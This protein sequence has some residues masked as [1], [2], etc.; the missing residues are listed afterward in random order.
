[1]KTMHNP[2]GP[3]ELLKELLGDRA[4]TELAGHIGEARATISLILNGRTAVTMDL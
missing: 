2:A 1:M 4:I 3:G